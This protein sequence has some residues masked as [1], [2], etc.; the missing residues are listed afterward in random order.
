MDVP[1]DIYAMKLA[2]A[3]IINSHFH[4]LHHAIPNC[5][6]CGMSCDNLESIEIMYNQVICEACLWEIIL[7]Y[8]KKIYEYES[9]LKMGTKDELNDMYYHLMYG[10]RAEIAKKKHS[11]LGRLKFKLGI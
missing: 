8:A 5:T 7:E 1:Y 11:W 10:D 6:A 3:V 2:K 9:L 4:L